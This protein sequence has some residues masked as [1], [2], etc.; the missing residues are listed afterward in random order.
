MAD[1]KSVSIEVTVVERQWLSVC[2]TNQI[3][4]LTRGRNK[5]MV[6]GDI[7]ILRGKEIDALRALLARMS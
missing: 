5:E 2:I 6:G 1:L 4:A 7:W 3:Q